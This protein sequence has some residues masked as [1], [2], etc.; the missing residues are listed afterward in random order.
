MV[1]KK[2]EK[3]EAPQPNETRPSLQEL[4]AEQKA[5][6]AKIRKAQTK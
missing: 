3:K 4:A 2:D 5:L 6:D 1:A